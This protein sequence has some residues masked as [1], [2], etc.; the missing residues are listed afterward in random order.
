VV[1]VERVEVEQ[2]HVPLVIEPPVLEVPQVRARGQGAAE[3]AVRRA[4]DTKLPQV[5][6]LDSAPAAPRR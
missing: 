4:A 1:E 5:D 2:D 6:L 3:A